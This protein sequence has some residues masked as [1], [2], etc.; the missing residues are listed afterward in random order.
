MHQVFKSTGVDSFISQ[1]FGALS[2]SFNFSPKIKTNN[3]KFKKFLNLAYL[4]IEIKFPE[5][6]IF[7]T[8][9]LDRIASKQINKFSIFSRNSL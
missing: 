2:L 8:R 4:Q 5:S 7:I 1:V 3:N 9:F 6:R